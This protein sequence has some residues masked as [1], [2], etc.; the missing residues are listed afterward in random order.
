MSAGGRGSGPLLNSCGA[1]P[2]SKFIR[3]AAV[4]AVLL[5]PALLVAPAAAGVYAGTVTGTFSNFQTTGALINT[6]GS[7]GFDGDPTDAISTGYG[8]SSIS[9]GATGGFPGFTASTLTFTGASFAFAR[10]GDPDAGLQGTPFKLGTLTY[11]NGTS[12]T[13]SLL[14]G[15]DLNLQIDGAT[16]GGGTPTTID[17]TTLTLGFLSTINTG[18][19]AQRDSDFLSFDEL[20]PADDGFGPTFNVVEGGTATIDIY[21]EIIGDP[22]A[23]FDHIDNAGG[24]GFI[25]NGVGTSDDTIVNPNI[26]GVPEPATWALMILGFA[27][28][29]A[30]L[31]ARRKAVAAA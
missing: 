10:G 24:N 15:A 28:I 12:V 8:T 3:A 5:S 21:G 1:F 4:A 13:G 2:M 22:Q 17:G 19:S 6:D 31:R 11:Y 7:L 20:D 26:G 29:G 30:S 14:Y 9:W 16:V 27:G 25:G 23:F 18:T